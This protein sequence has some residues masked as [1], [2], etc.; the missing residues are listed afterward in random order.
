MAALLWR[1]P[2]GEVERGKAEASTD[3]VTGIAIAGT[4]EREG[5]ARGIACRAPINIVGLRLREGERSL[6]LDAPALDWS[7][8]EDGTELRSSVPVAVTESARS[9]EGGGEKER[10]AGV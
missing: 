4:G 1:E 7:I 10:A 8:D 9:R 2:G 5:A 3:C 6:N